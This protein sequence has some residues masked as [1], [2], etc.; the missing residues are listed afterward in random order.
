[1][2]AMMPTTDDDERRR[3]EADAMEDHAA[4]VGWANEQERLAELDRAEAEALDEW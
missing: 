3:R 4:A 1:M 2:R